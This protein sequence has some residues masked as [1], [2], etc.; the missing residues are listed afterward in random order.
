MSSPAA[1]GSQRLAGGTRVETERSQA[2]C[3]LL[4]L[5]GALGKERGRFRESPWRN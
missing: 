5:A 3:Q 1:I 4:A 2:A